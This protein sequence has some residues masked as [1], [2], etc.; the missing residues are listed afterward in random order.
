MD[1]HAEATAANFV[2]ELEAVDGWE[3]LF[4]HR[5][6]RREETKE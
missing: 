6:R 5:G 1:V 2:E 3:R 4:R